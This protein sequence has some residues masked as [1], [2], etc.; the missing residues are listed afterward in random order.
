MVF[1]DTAGS[2]EIVHIKPETREEAEEQET[3]KPAR[4]PHAPI[5]SPSILF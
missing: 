5:A 4:G 2:F 3:L 1:S